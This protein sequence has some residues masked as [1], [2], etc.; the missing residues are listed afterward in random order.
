MELYEEIKYLYQHL[1]NDPDIH[2]DS[3]YLIIFKITT[4]QISVHD[5]D[6][7]LLT[8]SNHPP[9]THIPYPEIWKFNH[10]PHYLTPNS[11]ENNY[12]QLDI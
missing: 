9:L 12:A 8:I 2:P 10:N 11:K 5:G 3:K 6:D 7:N 1:Q 4:N